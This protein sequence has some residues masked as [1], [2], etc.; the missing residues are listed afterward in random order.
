MQHMKF[1][2]IRMKKDEYDL[3]GDQMFGGKTSMT[4]QN[5]RVV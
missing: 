1:Y 5:S 3:Y 4:L 2:L